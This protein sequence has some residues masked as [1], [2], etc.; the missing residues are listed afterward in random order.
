MNTHTHILQQPCKA[1]RETNAQ[2]TVARTAAAD[3]AAALAVRVAAQD[4]ALA[5]AAAE[6]AVAEQVKKQLGETRA[7]LDDAH[8]ARDRDR[9]AAHAELLQARAAA[10]REQRKAEAALATLDRKHAATTHR[11]DRDGTA[12]VAAESAVASLRDEVRRLAT[13]AAVAHE[14]HEA[15]ARSVAALTAQL[16]ERERE[17][18]GL[19]TAHAIAQGDLARAQQ[20]SAV[21]AAARRPGTAGGGGGASRFAN[22][23]A[24]MGAAGGS[25]SFASMAGRTQQLD[26]SALSASGALDS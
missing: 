23:V 18:S 7:A 11:A 9:G 3:K 22:L 16:R 26:V 5:V 6:R 12:L 19:R 25:S 13:Q 21:L 10:A 1:L 4:G 14:A 2:E 24:S 15:A 8:E 17:L 20:Q